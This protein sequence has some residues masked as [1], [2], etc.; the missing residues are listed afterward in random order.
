MNADLLTHTHE[1][2]QCTGSC[3]ARGGSILLIIILFRF[4]YGLTE[5]FI[6][7]QFELAVR[8]FQLAK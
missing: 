6:N 5:I 7:I 8:F 4:Y 1:S 3:K 2:S